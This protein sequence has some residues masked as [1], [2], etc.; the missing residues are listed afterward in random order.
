LIYQG[1]SGSGVSDIADA[2]TKISFKKSAVLYTVDDKSAVLHTRT[3]DA[4]SWVFRTA[5]K[6]LR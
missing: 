4:V 6:Q 2:A 3:A 5:L 1:I